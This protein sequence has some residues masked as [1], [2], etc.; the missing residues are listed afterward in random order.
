MES[1][2]VRPRRGTRTRPILLVANGHASHVRPGLVSG[3]ESELASRGA[4]CRKVVTESADEL[5]A[6]L[7]GGCERRVVLVG[8]D[9][10]VHAA[11]NLGVPPPELALIPAGGANNIARSLGIPLDPRAAARLAVEGRAQPI[12]AIEALTPSA[13]YVAVEGVSTGFLSEARS[14]YHEV[15]SE[16]VA[17]AMAAGATALAHFHPAGIRVLHGGFADSFPMVQLFVANLPLYAFGLHVAP[18]ADPTDGLLD[19]V[20]IEGNGRRDAVRMVMRLRR[21]NDLD[22]A[23]THHWRS[24]HVRLDTQGAVPVVADSHVF[25]QGRVELRVLA[26]ELPIVRP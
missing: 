7:T 9:G 5:A 26:R 17:S 23:D 15:S 16:H 10:T 21:G 4:D 1:L 20:A 8:G 14:Q 19:V 13:R 3:V 24:E 25:E 22:R 12:D 18:H 2:Q 11:A 6:L